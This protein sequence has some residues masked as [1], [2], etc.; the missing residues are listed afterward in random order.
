MKN[1]LSRVGIF[2]M[3][4]SAADGFGARAADDTKDEAPPPLF[5][6][7]GTHSRA[8][9]GA[10][11]QAQRYFDQGVAFIT[12]FNH[13]EGLRAMEHAVKLSPECA[14]AWWG[15]ALACSPHINNVGV[16]GV[17][18]ERAASALVRAKKFSAACT[19]AERALIDALKTRF[20]DDAKAPRRPLDEDYAAA[21]RNVWRSH[22]DDADIGAWT[23]D[24]M[25]MLRP[26][27]MWQKNGEP[28]PGTQEAV[29]VLEATLRLN[30][31]QPLANHLAVHAY[32]A[33]AQPE[34]GDA[35]ANRLRELTPGLGHM[36]HMSSHI[37]V[38]RG[39]WQEAIVA[40]TQAIA[41]NRSYRETAGRPL[42]GYLSYMGHDY[43]MLT[44]AA[45]M[46]G[47]SALAA[48]TMRD[49]F[50]QMPPE[51]K[52]ESDIGDG[53][54]AM[55][56]DVMKRFGQWDKILAEPE[57]LARYTHARAWRYLARGIARAAQGDPVGARAEERDFAAARA[58][59]AAG[60]MYRKNPL[61]DVMEI[62]ARLLDGEILLREGKID[63]ALA[64]LQAAVEREDKL[65]YAEPP[66]WAQPV[67]QALGAAL[68]QRN[69]L[70][71]AE[72]VYREDLARTADNGWSLFGLVQCLRLQN[73]NL[74]EAAALETCFKHV[75]AHAD[76]TLT[77]S[78]FC[79][80]GT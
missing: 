45:M 14:M 55:H 77:S 7:I 59:I 70:L 26:W 27:D 36:V 30:P 44:Y 63:T 11:P 4:I 65:R 34:R 54:F 18:A 5:A 20:S 67:R 68:L 66:A 52:R 8:I 16:S 76:V 39:R 79:Q 41:A 49:L 38:R 22:P 80:P 56:F 29:A 9:T 78:C 50:A 71:E 6:G 51:W 37:D 47:Q 3:M 43:H 23:A 40:N 1:F 57:P 13:D 21:M 12:S 62:A 25:M 48:Q 19:P 42:S 74:D 75:W 28:H 31:R 69:R 17:R 73:K 46:S 35:A 10:L 33:S 58:G 53:Y 24:A 64:A 2:W 60:A 32:E 72:L 61:A 15:V